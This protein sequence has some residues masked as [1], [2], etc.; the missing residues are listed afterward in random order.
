MDVFKKLMST[1]SVSGREH[2]L[3]VVIEEMLKDHV[4]SITRDNMGNLIAFKK[5]T[6]PNA[7]KLMLAGHMDEI[8]FIVTHIQDN[9]YIRINSIGGISYVAAAYGTVVFENGTKGVIVPEAGVGANDYN[10]SKFVIDIG[11]KDKKTAMTKVNFADTCA[12]IPHVERLMGGVYC[13]RP[14]DDKLGCAIMIRAA[15]EAKECANDTY[16]VFTVQEE[17]GCRGSKTSSYAIMPDYAI[18]YDVT[19]TGD[20]QG[21]KPMEVKLGNGAA[22]QIK[23]SS[24]ICDIDFVRAVEKIAKENKIPYQLEI[25]E[26]GG[27]DTSSMQMTGCGAKATAIS[28]PTRYIHSINET[29]NKKDYDACVDLTVEIL[30][31]Y[32]N[33]I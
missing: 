28:V 1:L 18:A 29:I 23:D 32:L 3:T 24:V 26:G 9:G 33:N 2:A 17:V 16:F 6:A 13:G 31:T 25:L 7:K 30:K 8:G 5:G 11:A 22:I 21:S 4:D 15:L 14:F 12:M 20:A 19:G 27:T 10:Q